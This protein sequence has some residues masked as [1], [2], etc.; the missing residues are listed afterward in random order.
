[1]MMLDVN[2]CYDMCLLLGNMMLKDVN[3]GELVDVLLL[4]LNGV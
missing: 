3:V 2:M 1:M 4:G